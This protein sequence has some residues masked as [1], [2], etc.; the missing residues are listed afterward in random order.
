M[1]YIHWLLLLVYGLIVAA[2]MIAVLM[3]NRQPAKTMAWLLVLT[4][5][6]LLGIILYFFFGQNTRKERFISQQSLDQLT[7]RSMLEF[8]E[9]KNLVLP[10]NHKTLIQ[11]FANQSW[12]LPFKDNE[13]DIFTDGYHFFHALLQEIGRAEHHIH[14]DTYIM[15]DDPLG[16]LVADALIDKAQQG[17]EVRVIYDDVGCWN[18]KKAF[19]ERMRDAGIEVHGFMPVKFPVFT[20]KVNYRNH[21]KLC[22]VDGRVG[23]V[24]GMNIAMRYIKGRNNRGWRDTH[25]RIRGGAVFGIQRAFLVDWYFVDRTLISDHS[26]YPPILEEGGRRNFWN[27]ES[28]QASLIGRVVTKVNEVKEEG[29]MG[30]DCIVQIVTSSP[31]SEW[32]DIMQGYIRILLEAKKYVY[33]ETPYFLPTE[34]VLLAMRTAAL[35]GVDVRVM[36]PYKTDAKLVEWASR[37]YVHEVVSAGVKIYLY[38]KGF[39][40]SK[41]LVSD[42]SM[43][44]VGSSNVDFR[45]FEN[46]FEGNAFIYDRDMALRMKEVYMNDVNDS[47]LLDDVENLNHRPFLKR[48]WESVVRLLSP[49]L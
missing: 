37:S 30:S 26:Y 27:S 33:I 41:L 35:T 46:N 11:L 31:I 5:L 43:C 23:F 19:W 18:V 24:G 45:S 32:P 47:V 29:D 21:R 48:L 8:V 49:L 6:P 44:T 12:A 17:V 7:K 39:N 3:D 25:L 22:V 14:L 36:I 16:Y 34:P 10:E 42:D 38:Q 1:I 2:A 9:Q 13:T 28:Q 4:F 20:S 15:E 40:H